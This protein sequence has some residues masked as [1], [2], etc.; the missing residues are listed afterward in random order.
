MVGPMGV[1]LSRRGGLRVDSGNRQRPPVS[2][3]SLTPQLLQL[4]R[5]C[6]AGRANPDLHASCII[7]RNLMTSVLRVLRSRKCGIMMRLMVFLRRNIT[8]PN[9]KRGISDYMAS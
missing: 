3:A 8:C 1:G 2:R 7:S 5:P 9:D 4:V 6:N